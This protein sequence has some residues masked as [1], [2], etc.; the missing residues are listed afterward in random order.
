MIKCLEIFY[1]GHT[2]TIKSKNVLY[3]RSLN[4]I[5]SLDSANLKIPLKPVLCQ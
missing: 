5:S 1:D 4:L 3:I 2:V